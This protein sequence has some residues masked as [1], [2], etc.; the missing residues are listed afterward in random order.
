MKTRQ[1][2]FSP[3]TQQWPGG[4]TALFLFWNKEESNQCQKIVVQSKGTLMVP[5]SAVEARLR[6]AEQQAAGTLSGLARTTQQ[7]QNGFK[8]NSAAGCTESTTFSSEAQKSASEQ[9]FCKKTE[10]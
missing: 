2:A 1:A 8:T 5:W 10:A 6:V 4:S 9:M 7:T 3:S